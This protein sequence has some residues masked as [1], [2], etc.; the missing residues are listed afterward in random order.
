M[1]MISYQYFCQWWVLWAS[2]TR[3]I[4]NQ[5]AS[6]HYT[7][8]KV[9]GEK[10]TT[11]WGCTLCDL[12]SLAHFF[13]S[14]CFSSSVSRFALKPHKNCESTKSLMRKVILPSS[15]FAGGRKTVGEP[16]ATVVSFWKMFFHLERGMKKELATRLLSF[17]LGGS[18]CCLSHC[19][20]FVCPRVKPWWPSSSHPGI[21]SFLGWSKSSG[22]IVQLWFSDCQLGLTPRGWLDFLTLSC[23][24][25]LRQVDLR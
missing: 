5:A 24:Y 6:Y 17:Y 22:E 7:V 14:A 10:D 20:T 21:N 4:Q 8:T 1:N 9:T 13:T 16:F 23:K 15:Y 3:R 12:P 25:I 19:K 18:K 2:F 11:D